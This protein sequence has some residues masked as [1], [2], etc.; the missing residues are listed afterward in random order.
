MIL[1]KGHN[2]VNIKL[3]SIQLV[4]SQWEHILHFIRATLR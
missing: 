3:S 2:K 4:G 1:E